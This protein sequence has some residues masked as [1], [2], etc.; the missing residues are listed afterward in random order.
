MSLQGG[1]TLISKLMTAIRKPSKEHSF[2][3][4]PEPRRVK[5]NCNMEHNAV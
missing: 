3:Q 5:V 2:Q 4:D 1:G